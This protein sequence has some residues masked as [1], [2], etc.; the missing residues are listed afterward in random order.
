MDQISS[1]HPS[2]FPIPKRSTVPKIIV[3]PDQMVGGQNAA[4]VSP[5][6]R[7]FRSNSEVYLKPVDDMQDPE[8]Q[9]IMPI[10]YAVDAAGTI[11]G[12]YSDF[13]PGIIADQSQQVPMVMID[14]SQMNNLIH[15]NDYSNS[16]FNNVVN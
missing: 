5:S 6:K 3:T 7:L 10:A 1:K 4:E 8:E 2:P 14:S 11:S 15:A 12:G 16:S 9:F 13:T